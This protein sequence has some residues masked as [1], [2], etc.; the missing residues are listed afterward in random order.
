[1]EIVFFD[2]FVKLDTFS[3]NGRLKMEFL[4]LYNRLHLLILS[5]FSQAVMK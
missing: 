2:I 1:M 4:T 3:W 5:N